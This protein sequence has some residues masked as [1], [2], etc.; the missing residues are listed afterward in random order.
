[1]I[2]KTIFSY[3]FLWQVSGLNKID[4]TKESGAHQEKN[5]NCLKRQLL[6]LSLKN[7]NQFYT[8]RLIVKTD[9][10]RAE[11]INAPRAKMPAEIEPKVSVGEGLEKMVGW[12]KAHK[13][14]FA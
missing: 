6:F 13:D 11:M 12:I 10:Y 8:C 2:R 3:H 4:S 5:R 1:M 14:V 9:L 7:L